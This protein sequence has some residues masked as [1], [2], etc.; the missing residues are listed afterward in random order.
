MRDIAVTNVTTFKTVVGQGFSLNVKVTVVNQGDVAETFNLTLYAGSLAIKTQAMTLGISISA[1]VTFIWNT[2]G[3][4]EG[5]YD[6]KAVADTVSGEM[7]IVDNT[8]IG[9]WIVITIPGDVTGDIWVDMQDISIII[10]NFMTSQPEWDPNCDVN[11]DLS[12]DMADISIAIDNFM[13]P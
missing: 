1:T 2:T 13:Q 8:L 10:D 6:I 11:D 4:D 12:I 9:G 7:D 5:I 3:F